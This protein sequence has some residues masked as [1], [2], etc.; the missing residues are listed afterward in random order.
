MKIEYFIYHQHKALGVIIT[1]NNHTIISSIDSSYSVGPARCLL[2]IV[3]DLINI[4]S[5]QFNEFR[6]SLRSRHKQIISNRYNLNNLVKSSGVNNLSGFDLGIR[7][8]NRVLIHNS[9]LKSDKEFLSIV[10]N[11]KTDRRRI[12][13]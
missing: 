8:L 3:S 4:L 5:S 10:S 2:L 1:E 6:P 7:E 9:I 13:L 11:S 12:K